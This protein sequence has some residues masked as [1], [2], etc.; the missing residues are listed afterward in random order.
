MKEAHE[1]DTPAALDPPTTNFAT[2]GDAVDSANP[3]EE[4]ESYCTNCSQNGTTRLLL[5]KI[6][7]FREVIIMSFYCPHCSFQ[8]SEIQSAG[9]IQEKGC[10]ISVRLTAISDFSRQV[11]KSETA[12]CKFEELEVEVPAQRGQL[13]NVEGLLSSMLEDLE[14]GQ[15]ARKTSQPEAHAKIETILERARQLL[16]GEGFPLTFSVDDSAGNSWIERN[17]KDGAGKWWK[18]EY[19]R[20]TAQNEELHLTDA[21]GD[22]SKDDEE[23][24]PKPAVASSSNLPKGR[25]EPAIGEDIVPGEVYAFPATC[26]GCTRSCTTNMKMVNIPHFKEVVLMSTSCEH[27]GYRSSE[28]KTGGAVPEKGR[29]ITLIVE[30]PEDLTR[31]VLKSESATMECDD[32]SLHIAPGTLGGRFTTLEGL[33]TQVRDD[34]RNQVFDTDGNSKGGDSAKA[35]EKEAWDK[36][37]DGMEQAA[38]GRKKFTVSLVDPLAASYIQSYAAAGEAQDPQLTIEDYIRTAE[39]EEELGLRDMNTEDYAPA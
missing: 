11:I 25:P 13:T 21:G 28:V 17:P 15:S 8:N 27:C 30:R 3:V 29:K 24:E 7:F 39:E 14:L 1:P 37:F 6:P 5:T 10:K 16:K 23:V 4:I 18:N 22:N 35:G 9:E 38:R 26:P 19:A 36:F 2:I 31:D 32:L 20:S 12:L 34:L 33:L